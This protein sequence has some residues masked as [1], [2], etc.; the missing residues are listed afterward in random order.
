MLYMYN[1]VKNDRMTYS[2]L[3]K[4]KQRYWKQ[5]IIKVLAGQVTVQITD[6]NK[7]NPKRPIKFQYVMFIGHNVWK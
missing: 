6:N 3:E 2:T 5:R 7:Q 1:R 4:Y